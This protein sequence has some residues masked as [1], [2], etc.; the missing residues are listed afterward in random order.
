MRFKYFMHI[1][2]FSFSICFWSAVCDSQVC[3]M[4]LLVGTV[5]G[6]KVC[7]RQGAL[8]VCLHVG[9]GLRGREV[10]LPVVLDP[11]LRAVQLVQHSCRK[12]GQKKR[13][14]KQIYA[15]LNSLSL[16]TR[17]VMMPTLSSLAAA[18]VVTTT[19]SRAINDD[20]VGLIISVVISA[21]LS[22][23]TRPC[24]RRGRLPYSIYVSAGKKA[25]VILIRCKSF[26]CERIQ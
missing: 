13:R 15:V 11:T 3:E 18:E 25:S 14:Q 12:T 21:V 9:T 5:E 19:T 16:N 1:H 17:A 2:G 8:H 10:T 23:N 20:P 6:H 24:R 4:V 7:P 22:L 26:I